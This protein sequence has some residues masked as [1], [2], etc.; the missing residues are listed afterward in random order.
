[1]SL[2]LGQN[3]RFSISW[4]R[5]FPTGGG[6]LNPEGVHFYS[7]F[8]DALLAAGITPWVNLYHFDVPQA[9]SYCKTSDT[10]SS[11]PC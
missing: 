10:L 4:S 9:S 2:L 6:A 5:L 7:T 3:Y 11:Y 1:M 8:I